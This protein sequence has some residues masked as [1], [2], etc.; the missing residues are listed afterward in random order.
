M[1]RTIVIDFR[2]DL[3]V[4]AKGDISVLHFAAQNYSGYLSILFL[5][6]YSGFNVDA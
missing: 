3:N 4:K 1:L 5:S 2:A 6:Q